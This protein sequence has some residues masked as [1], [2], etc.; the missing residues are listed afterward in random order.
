MKHTSRYTL[1]IILSILLLCNALFTAAKE[2]E[3]QKEQKRLFYGLSVDLDL[4]EPFLSLINSNRSGVNA[5]VQADIRHTFF[6]VFEMGYSTYEGASHYSY[7]PE[8]IDQ[9]NYRYHVNGTYYKIGVDFNLLS[10]NYA[11]PVV[12]IGYLGIRY[13]ISPF[14]YQIENLK[15][16]DFYWKPS[17]PYLFNA[18]GSSVGQWA[19]F[20]LGVKTPIY[21]NFCMG[22]SARFKQLKDKAVHSSF[23]PGYGE[24]ENDTWG[25]RYTI[26]YFFPFTR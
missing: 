16:S 6:P 2:K 8:I 18:E 10:K 4:A 5:S 7:L 21:K 19:E 11:K 20:V 25:F 22:V 1:K 9:D 14:N 17:E 26:S 12:S 3:E 23:A 24:K 13:C 15:V